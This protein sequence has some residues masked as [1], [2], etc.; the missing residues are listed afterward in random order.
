[1]LYKLTPAGVFLVLLL[2]SIITHF[3]LP[4]KEIIQFPYNYIGMGIIVLGIVFNFLEYNLFKRNKTT[5]NPYI[6]P[7]KLVTSGIFKV[8]RNPFYLGQ[9]LKLVGV[10]ILL[11][12]L[13]TFLFPIIYILIIDRVYIPLEEKNLKHIFGLKYLLYK[14]KVRRWL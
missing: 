5:I 4:I 7:S 3:I 13:I 1:M 11:G 9:V 12:S 14:K 10:A 2:I 6:K 8:S